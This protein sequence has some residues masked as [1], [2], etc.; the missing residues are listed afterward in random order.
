MSIRS[1]LMFLIVNFAVLSHPH[2]VSAQSTVAITKRE[3]LER[4]MKMASCQT[5]ASLL[6]KAVSH[7][8]QPDVSPRWGP[9]D[10]L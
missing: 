7:V 6:R 1:N 10:T 3:G 2:D 9:Q 4:V 8:N 5:G